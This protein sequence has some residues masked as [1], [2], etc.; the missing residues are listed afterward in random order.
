MGPEYHKKLIKPP[1][2]LFVPA[3]WT[4]YSE[5]M[6]AS[7]MN[8]CGAKGWK[9]DIVPDTIYGLRVT[10]ACNIH[11]V[12]YAVGETLEDKKVADRV[13]L[14]NLERII[15]YHTKWRW[16]RW[17]RRQRAK[18]YYAAVKHFGG[19]A[20]WAGKEGQNHI[21]PASA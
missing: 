8:G 16:L 21:Q 9:F 1:L 11:D 4:E 17:L 10:D 6:R 20:Y 18:K 3:W 7:W 13:L 2:R 14:N 12:M 5:S 15:K 19:P